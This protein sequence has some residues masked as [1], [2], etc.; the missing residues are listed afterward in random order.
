MFGF[1]NS[2]QICT[3][4]ACLTPLLAFFT[5]KSYGDAKEM[6]P[7]VLFGII[8]FTIMALA[9]EEAWFEMEKYTDKNISYY[10]TYKIDTVSQTTSRILEKSLSGG[11]VFAPYVCENFHEYVVNRVNEDENIS[12]YGD[13]EV[14]NEQVPA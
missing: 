5:A 8:M 7:A 3:V 11:A 6:A 14:N 1:K 4:L 13:N 9:P 2:D 10:P 12:E